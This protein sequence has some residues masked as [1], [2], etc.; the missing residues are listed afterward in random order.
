MIQTTNKLQEKDYKSNTI[1]N[2][3]L[4]GLLERINKPVRV[5]YSKHLD[6]FCKGIAFNKDKGVIVVNSNLI[7]YPS[8]ID[9]K[10]KKHNNYNKLN[11]SNISNK[12]NDNKCIG[13]NGESPTECIKC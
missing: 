7:E 12:N 6:A 4:K 9:Y 8:I 11:K 5:A 13:N 2:Y 3:I 10:V 1:S